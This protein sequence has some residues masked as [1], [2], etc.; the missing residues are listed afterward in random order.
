VCSQS[1]IVA[2]KKVVMHVRT[3]L[4]VGA[5]SLPISTGWAGKDVNIDDPVER[6][7]DVCNCRPWY[8]LMGPPPAHMLALGMRLFFGVVL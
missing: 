5:L 2:F 1:T 3:T 7:R 8:I 4:R 6:L